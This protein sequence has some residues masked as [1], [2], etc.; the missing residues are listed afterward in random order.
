MDRFF[1]R[2]NYA[3]VP[4]VVFF[5]WW[6]MCLLFFHGFQ[7]FQNGLSIACSISAEGNTVLKILVR[8]MS[9]GFSFSTELL[10]ANPPGQ[11]QI[12]S[13]GGLRW[14]KGVGFAVCFPVCDLV[15]WAGNLW[16]PNRA[17]SLSQPYFNFLCYGRIHRT[18]KRMHKTSIQFTEK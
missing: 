13:K 18:F 10:T 3:R 17:A 1:K 4:T 11:R 5:G 7:I 15:W 8:K 12:D 6:D 16:M 9:T 14:S 2:L